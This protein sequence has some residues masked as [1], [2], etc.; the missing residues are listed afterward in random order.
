MALNAA[1]MHLNGT[2]NETSFIKSLLPVAAEKK[3]GIIGMRVPAI[4]NIFKPNGI[5]TMKQAMGMR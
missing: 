5:T 2:G 3:M 4:G 1:D